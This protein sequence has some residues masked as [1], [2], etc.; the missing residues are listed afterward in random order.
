LNKTALPQAKSPLSGAAKAGGGPS[1]YGIYIL[2]S[3]YSIIALQN[4]DGPNAL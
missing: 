4:I 2:F 1:I 3:M